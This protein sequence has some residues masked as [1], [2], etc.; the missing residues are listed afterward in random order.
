[1]PD[2]TLASRLPTVA[3]DRTQ[4]PDRRSLTPVRAG[5]LPA[6]TCRA[7]PIALMAHLQRQQSRQHDHARGHERERALQHKQRPGRP[8]PVYVVLSITAAKKASVP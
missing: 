7:A 2:S 5:A 8:H 6:E 4:T 1:L 3:I